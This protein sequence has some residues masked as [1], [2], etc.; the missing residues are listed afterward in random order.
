MSDFRILQRFIAA[1]SFLLSGVAT[2]ASWTVSV[3][4]EFGL[5]TVTKGGASA[6][7]GAFVYWGK[8]WAF[9]HQQ[10]QF[11]VVAPFEY[12]FA[13]KNTAF[14][15]DFTNRI[16]KASSQQLVW[17]FDMNARSTTSDVIGGGV[18]FNFDLA[19]VGAELGEPV[20]LPGNRGWAWGRSG[21]SRIEMRFDPPLASV[22]YE[23]G[24]K[25]EVRAFF[26]KGEVPQGHRHYVATLNIS[27]DFAIGPTTA[28]RYGLDD[29]AAWPTDILDWRASP[30]DLSFLN[31]P[32]KPAG[33]RGFLKVVKDKLAF[34]DGT[35]VR[36]WGTNLA[37]HALFDTSRENV[38]QQARRLSELGFN[39]V[40]LHHHDSFWVSPNIFGDQ[41][42]QDTRNL[43]PVMLEKLD[44][45][46]KCLK[47]EGIYVWLD[48]HAQRN[49]KPG[50]LIDDFGEIS[51][52]KPLA[53]LKGYN[54][55]NSSIE[56]AMMRFNEAYVNRI[57]QYTNTR[58]RDEPAIAAML[59][60]NENDI[61]NH[62]GNALL[63]DKGVP[64][65]NSLYTR[66]AEAFAAA[67]GLPKDKTWRSWEHGP[68]KLFLND[69]ERRFN[70]AMIAHLRAQGVKVPIVTTSTWGNPL[71]SLPALTVGN[72]IDAHSY[73]GIGALEKNPLYAA[74]LM[75]WMAAA[76][77]AGKPLSVTEWNVEPFPAPDR[78]S[79]PLYVA[80]SAGYQGWSALMQYA[81][82]KD[83]LNG[84]GG[85]SNWNSFHDPALVATLPAAALLYRR[86]DV[87]EAN[88]VYAF[89]PS[90]EQLF[91]QS[92]SPQNSVAL[93]TAAEKG[94]LVVA[95]PKTG[96][97]P[98]LEQ[99]PI[100]A[101]AKVITDA[102]QSLIASDAAGGVS[103]TG[104]L[105]R[106]WDDGVY[107]ID[108][109]RSQAA[110]GWIG[111]RKIGLADVDFAIT[112]RNATVAVQSLDRN[113]IGKSGAI[114]ISL[115]A[116]SVPKTADRLPFS[117]E[118]VVGRIEIRAP[119][120]L[121]LYK[122][123]RSGKET[124]PYRYSKN[125]PAQGVEE[126]PVPYKDGRYAVVLDRSLGTYWLVL[127]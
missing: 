25:S 103:D 62:F 63:P 79:V 90:K 40:R 39:L 66:Q 19:G 47:D 124:S 21:G 112:T 15:Y 78:H 55:V 23:Q 11:K 16:R 56:Q 59:I 20:L 87:K 125:R 37:S 12:S 102:K 36:F 110:M 48:L 7:S 97:L 43:S 76:Q 81:Y 42:V 108:T 6:M 111:G 9:V 41:S 75:N 52:G 117:S 4:Q 122:E 73:G 13:G 33:K 77:V 31:A 2:A 34:A 80:A 86:G 120:G 58:Y 53:E 107:T 45:W 114:L 89:A 5:P 119:R 94:K 22:Y 85:P 50:D 61:T 118:P 1:A 65:H 3:D 46:I 123:N 83:A 109:P 88:D 68:A 67:S 54:Y 84:P 29:Q 38:P 71:S 30:V 104:E 115:G 24:R 60:T 96:E 105:R 116:R 106:N 91:G 69:L 100:P 10:A 101:G 28:E 92:I 49:F 95:M 99:S 26:Y 121:R 44:W 32:E 113:P 51:K 70:A 8:N 57:N 82:S 74:N 27:A 64:K 72:M 93:R 98:W 35:A 17:E 127:K 14:N 18:V 126:V